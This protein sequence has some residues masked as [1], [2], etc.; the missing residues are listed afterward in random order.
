MAL[1]II[2]TDAGRA[3]LVNAANNGTNPVVI[4]QAGISAT[5]VVPSASATNLPGEIKRLS[6]I[7]GDVVADD[8][9][10]LIVRDEGGDTFTVRSF[11]LYLGDG[12][13][14][15]I[16]GQ[17]DPILEKSAQAM[18]L[19]AIDIA[20]ADV[21]GAEISFGDA[22]FLLPPATET[23]QGVVELATDAEATAGTDAQRAVHPK[24]LKAAVTSW[25]NARL[26]EGAPSAFMKSLLTAASASALRIAIGLK[27]AA[28]KDEGAGNG[29]DADLLDG[30][31]GAYYADI[32]AR[33]G[34][35]PWGPSNDGAG[36]GLDAGMLAGQLPSYYTNIT[37]RLGYTP[38][39]AA[40]YTGADVLSKL[41]TV[42]G[43]G[44]GLD[45]DL[46]DGVQ[47]A[48]FARVDLGS[49]ASFAG[50]VAAP[51]LHSAGALRVDGE[52]TSYGGI[53]VA[54]SGGAQVIMSNAGDIQASRVG[55]TNGAVY[56]GNLG[57]YLFYNGS[58][59]SLSGAGGAQ[60]YMGGGMC[61]NSGND[62][63]GSG[64]DAD[65]LDGYQGADYNRVT[66][67]S[68]G[69]PGYIA[70]SNGLKECWGELFINANSNGYWAFP[71]GFS[72]W[73]APQV[74]VT[75][76]NGEDNASQ[77]TGITNLTLSG[78]NVYT[79]SNSAVRVY[80]RILGV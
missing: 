20:F 21:D 32:P 42:D 44:S 58:D 46:L 12:T 39:N 34:F 53:R 15:A 61:W 55:G 69:A 31:H 9:I 80:I 5:A 27:S 54:G 28:L 17:A 23:V 72:Q 11:G 6:T 38:L 79:A 67:Q 36:S 26:G 2:V 1:T 52:T 25:L 71:I 48:S 13:L 49:G 45:A 3:A 59:F 40:L 74:S 51:S 50:P 66:A 57:A 22:N 16:Y 43:A 78:I 24:G 62:G 73:V 77:V 68:L 7:S 75:V 14:F 33:L 10:H 30:Q 18:M 37:A 76:V 8:M 60:L 65:M 64:L 47:G 41:T 29:L 63:A 19:L 35:V 4:T 70:Y 56:F